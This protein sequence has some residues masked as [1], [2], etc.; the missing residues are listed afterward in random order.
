VV[1]S[2]LRIT[3]PG[4][5]PT[6]L[7]RGPVVNHIPEITSTPVQRRDGGDSIPGALAPFPCVYP[8]VPTKNTDN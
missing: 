8:H 2:T 3:T 5:A 4:Q 1:T 7:P 6:I